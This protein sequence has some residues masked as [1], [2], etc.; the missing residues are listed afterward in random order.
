MQPTLRE[1]AHAE[2]EKLTDEQ[3]LTVLAFIESV[4][5]A[6]ED[7]PFLNGELVFSGSPN[8][9]EDV[10]NILGQELGRSSS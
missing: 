3:I 1:Q 9:A 5:P 7:D 6:A 2:L 8:L 10:E 4:K